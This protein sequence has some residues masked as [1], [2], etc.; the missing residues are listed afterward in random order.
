MASSQ[1]KNHPNERMNATTVVC[2]GDVSMR[3]AKMRVRFPKGVFK[4]FGADLL[5][6]H[7]MPTVLP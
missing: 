3:A 6:L 2:P 5:V 7:S 4:G 1:Q